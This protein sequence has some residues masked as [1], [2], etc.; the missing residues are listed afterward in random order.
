[1]PPACW[2]A[3]RW[4]PGKVGAR[5]TPA[6]SASA[7]PAA[8]PPITGGAIWLGAGPLARDLHHR[9]AVAAAAASLL[10]I[11]A[12]YHVVDAVQAVMAQ[13]LRGYK[14]ATA[15][16]VIY[17]V[18]LWG[19]GLGGGYLLGLTDGLRPRAR[20]R[21]LLDGGGGQPERWPGRA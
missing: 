16:M 4:A 14:R 9:C 20:R 3:R 11:V 7:S 19:V 8:S 13:V 2:S 17:A 6:C 5:D 15:P 10:A 21:R 18:S 1:M 12:L